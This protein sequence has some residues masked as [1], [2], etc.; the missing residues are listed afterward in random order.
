MRNLK[1]QKYA[2]EFSK[3][4][5]QK[6]IE[7]LI[8]FKSDFHVHAEMGKIAIVNYATVLFYINRANIFYAF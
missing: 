3:A 8:Y 7:N 1:N 4:Y 2:F 6:F 5:F